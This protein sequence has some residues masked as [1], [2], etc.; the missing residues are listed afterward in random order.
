MNTRLRKVDEPATG[1]AALL[2]RH[3]AAVSRGVATATGYIAARASGAEIGDEDA[4]V[5]STSRGI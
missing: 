4:D 1:N 2:K 5:S 3:E